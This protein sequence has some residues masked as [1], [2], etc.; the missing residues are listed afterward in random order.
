MKRVNTQDISKAMFIEGINNR[1]SH[2]K[3]GNTVK[4]IIS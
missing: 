1:R 4:N 2:S 3:I